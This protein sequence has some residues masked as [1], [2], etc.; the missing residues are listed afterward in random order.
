M[1][2]FREINGAGH[3]WF[4]K[5]LLLRGHEHVYLGGFLLFTIAKRQKN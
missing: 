1:N 5:I 2:S 3:K 4:G